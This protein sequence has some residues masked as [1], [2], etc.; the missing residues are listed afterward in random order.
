MQK[1]IELYEMASL[2]DAALCGGERA[3][4]L[5]AR[6]AL[7]MFERAMETFQNGS[8]EPPSAAEISLPVAA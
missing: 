8:T 5:K 1:L 6:L 2:N 3:A 7:S 4:I